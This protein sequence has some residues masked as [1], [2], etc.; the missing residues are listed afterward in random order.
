M[1]SLAE[2]PAIMTHA[3]VPAEQRALVGISDTLVRLS[4]GIEGL[5]DLIEDLDAALASTVVSS[6]KKQTNDSAANKNPRQ[7]AGGGE[8]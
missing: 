4:I 2:S 5:P 8:I 7:Q 1:E 3:S 6:D